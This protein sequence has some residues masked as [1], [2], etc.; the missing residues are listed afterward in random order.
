MGR[1][2]RIF[3]ASFFL[4]R[5]VLWDGIV[6]AGTYKVT[7]TVGDKSES[8]TIEVVDVSEQPG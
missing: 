3:F 8:N 2:W 4:M 7:V 1:F 5:K 6:A